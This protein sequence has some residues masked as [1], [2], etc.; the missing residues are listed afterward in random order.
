MSNA[1]LLVDDDAN[2]LA[3]HR[4]T[5]RQFNIQTAASGPEALNLLSGQTFAVVVADMHMSGMNGI[6][7]LVK[8]REVSPDTVRVMLTGDGATRTAVDAVNEGHIFR[9]LTKPCPTPAVVKAITAALEQYRL[10]TAER[11]LL[12]QTLSGTVRVLTEVLG[13]VN[14]VAFN[15]TL[16]IRKHVRCMAERLRLRDA[17]QYEV[18]AMLSQIG[19]IAL[20]PEMLEVVRAGGKLSETDEQRFALHASVAHDLLASI[21]RLEGIARMVA[22]QHQPSHVRWALQAVADLDTVEV[23]SALLHVAVEFERLLSAG[24][25]ETEAVERLRLGASDF[26]PVLIAILEATSLGADLPTT[27][28]P[29]SEL[30]LGMVLAESICTHTG[31]RLVT[32]GAEVTQPMLVRLAN[33]GRIGAIPDT[34]AVFLTPANAFEASPVAIS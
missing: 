34:V 15:T 24:L 1:I 3:A 19:C 9:F 17:W 27:N 22:R 26:D 25:A 13:L 14:P 31:M 11:E 7:L 32:R 20:P 28:V 8:V 23:G 10:V 2:V 4:R 33:F 6:Q 12:E 18:A 30:K 16:R 29:V 5:L 21:P